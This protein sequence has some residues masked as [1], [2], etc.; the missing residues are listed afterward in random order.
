LQLVGESKS[1]LDK[2]KRF[3]MPGFRPTPGYVREMK[4]YGILPN[5]LP[6]DA[7][8]DVYATDR[9]FWRSKWWQPEI[10]AGTKFSTK[11]YI[12]EEI[13]FP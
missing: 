8:I 4:R 11:L 3:D 12:T 5:D 1:V 6:D 2:D 10:S 7:F 13:S 9:A